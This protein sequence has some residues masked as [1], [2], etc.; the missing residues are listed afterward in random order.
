[1][2]LE[3]KILTYC[4]TLPVVRYACY[5]MNV[6]GVAKAAIAWA[7]EEIKK[8]NLGKQTMLNKEEIVKFN[9]QQIEHMDLVKRLVFD[10]CTDIVKRTL[11]HDQSKFDSEE[12][13][14]FIESRES[15]NASKDGKDSDYQKFL[16]S[17]AIQRHIHNNPHHPEYWDERGEAMPFQEAVIMFFDWKSRS[18]QR[19]TDF[20]SFWDFN[21]A[22][23]KNQPL[24]L[25][26]VSSLKATIIDR[27]ENGKDFNFRTSR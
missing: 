26:V 21:I 17:D 13:W 1:M 8:Q 12:Y 19:G 24:A 16:N 14:T 2:I 23:L 25:Q 27:I 10:F 6:E 15:L 11:V 3:D 4:R 9:K 18:L 20:N 5:E 22:K 7:I